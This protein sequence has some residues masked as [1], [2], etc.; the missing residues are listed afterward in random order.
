MTDLDYDVVIV[1]AGPVG[2]AFANLMG[3]YGLRTL[4]VD[5]ALEILEIPRA[6]GLCE[7]GSRVLDA[8]GVMTT[9]REHTLEINEIRFDIPLGNS[10]FSLNT[11]RKKN[12]YPEMR[13]FYQPNLERCLRSGLSQFEHV[14][15]LCET[16][17]LSHRDKGSSVEVSLLV[18]QESGEQQDI[19]CRFLVAC[20]GSSSSVRK[21][22]DIGYKGRTYGQEWLIFDAEND[23]TPDQKVVL[24]GNRERPGITMPA[25][26]GKR[27]WEFVVKENDSIEELFADGSIRQ[28]LAP[29][30]SIEELKIERKTTYTFHARSANEFRRG[31][32]FLVGDAAHVTPPFAGQGLMAGLRDCYNLAW[33]LKAVHDQTAGNALLETYQTERKPQVRQITFFAEFIGSMLLPQTRLSVFVRDRAFKL[34]SVLGMFSMN[35]GGG[36]RKLS[37]HIN[38]GLARHL[39]VSKLFGTGFEIPQIEV[40]SEPETPAL[41]DHVLGDHFYLIGV[42]DHPAS[43]LAGDVIQRWVALGGR[44][45]VFRTQSEDSLT[46]GSRE[47]SHE[48]QSLPDFLQLDCSDLSNN[49][50]FNPNRVLAIRPDK[51]IVV[52]SKKDKINK[53]LHH[54]ISQVAV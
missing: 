40:C 35:D 44:F 13:T 46:Q 15:L 9:F 47:Q 6:I 41:L 45:A 14:E 32:V 26:A 53:K 23:L 33:K 19:S 25:P 18:N 3:K 24:L 34:M 43:G 20:D 16:Q 50:L 29:W 10:L 11:Q 51:M 52:N 37:N 54:Y 17:Y 38:G 21:A 42:D 27:R 1:G 2:V 30:G 12:G 39:A 48:N 8:C 22:M 28:L 36:F 4:I 49:S 7:E 5:K 31:N